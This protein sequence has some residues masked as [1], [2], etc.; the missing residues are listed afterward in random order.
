VAPELAGSEAVL[1]RDVGDELRDLRELVV[2]EDVE[3]V[4][5]RVGAVFSE[6]E[7]AG[8]D[9]LVGWVLLEN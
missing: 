2:G 6:I 4:D 8:C 3:A 9:W 7:I 5:P 1:S